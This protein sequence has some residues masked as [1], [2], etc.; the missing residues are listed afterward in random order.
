ME[1][2][3]KQILSTIAFL[4]RIYSDNPK[5]FLESV[6]DSFKKGL[7][8]FI[9]LLLTLGLFEFIHCLIQ[10]KPIKIIDNIDLAISF[11]GFLLMFAGNFLERLFGKN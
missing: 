11:L 2:G 1:G 7:I 9:V 10:G 8:A 5:S 4:N 6:L 3:L